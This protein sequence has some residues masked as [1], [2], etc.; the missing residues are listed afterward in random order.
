MHLTI[1]HKD[2]KEK[3]MNKVL[4]LVSKAC[5]VVMWI[6]GVLFLFADAPTRGF[7]CIGL[8]SVWIVDSKL[9]KLIKVLSN[10]NP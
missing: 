4:D 8:A 1:N 3:H 9:D 6:C 5:I 10:A 7:V 2:T